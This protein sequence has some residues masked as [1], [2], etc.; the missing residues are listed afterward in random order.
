MKDI[1]VYSRNDQPEKSPAYICIGFFVVV[2][3]LISVCALIWMIWRNGNEVE[4]VVV[5]EEQ[6]AMRLPTLVI[7]AGHGGMDGGAVGSDGT[8]EKEINL[9]V[10]KRLATLFKLAGLDCVMTRTEDVMVVDDDV[11]ERRKMHDLKNR[12][13]IVNGIMEDGKE[14][15]LIS[16]HM[17]NFSVAKYSGLQVWYSKN[18]E[19]GEKLASAV[20][21]YARTWLDSEN[22]REIKSATSAIYLLD[23]AISPAILIECGFLSN[24]DECAKLKSVEYQTDLAAVIFAAVC[25]WVGEGSVISGELKK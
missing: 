24:P 9:A 10:A 12:L 2:L 19:Q 8:L 13:A 17:N 11:K 4:A 20:Q 16:I 21:S 1:V 3:I 7:D 25:E 5:S 15:V 23:R 18:N 14:A 6:S 22:D